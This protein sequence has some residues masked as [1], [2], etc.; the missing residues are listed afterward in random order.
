MTA[1][2]RHRHRQAQ[3]PA[4]RRLAAR[5]RTGRLRG[6]EKLLV[7]I[8]VALVVLPV[9]LLLVY[10]LVPPPLT[11]VMALRIVQGEGA[12]HEWVPLAGISPHLRHAVI[13]SEDNGFCTHRG[14]DWRAFRLA[15]AA[16]MQ[17]DGAAGGASTLTM[18]TARNLMLWPQRSYLRKVLEIHVASMIE[19]LWP[20]RRILEVYLNIA[21]WGPGL[22]GA[23]SAARYHFGVGADALTRAQA[24]RLAVV[25][26]APTR[27]SATATQGYVP[28]QAAAIQRRMG[29]LGPLLACADM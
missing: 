8:L 29:Q 2:H 15:V 17:G 22:F 10:R 14:V 18:Q 7:A 12:R 9:A 21:E 25:L 27:L 3:R 28:R 16:E 20:K 19:L 13:A 6:Y 4:P 23:E 1:L 5:L 11:S 24:A 26:P